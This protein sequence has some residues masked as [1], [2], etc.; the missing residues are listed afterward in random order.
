MYIGQLAYFRVQINSA[1]NKKDIHV[2]HNSFSRGEISTIK[3]EVI[4]LKE[5]V[6]KYKELNTAVANTSVPDNLAFDTPVLLAPPC[7]LA[8]S[9]FLEDNESRIFDGATSIF[10]ND[11]LKIK[12]H[13]KEEDLPQNQ[14]LETDGENPKAS[15]DDED[16]EIY[17]YG[18]G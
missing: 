12:E 15:S 13:E 1:S 5:Q 16:W 8:S 11:Y 2:I 18:D 17:W 6:N 7:S 14:V 4:T 9:T 3:E 10:R